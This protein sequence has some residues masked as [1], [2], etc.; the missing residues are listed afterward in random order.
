MMFGQP[1]IELGICTRWIGKMKSYNSKH[2]FTRFKRRRKRWS[3]KKR[4]R[5]C[6]NVSFVKLCILIV[7]DK[8]VKTTKVKFNFEQFLFRRSRNEPCRTRDHY[9]G[10]S[11]SKLKQ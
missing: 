1:R 2:L 7:I 8:S 10:I 3:E 11:G 9:C 4:K 6:Y 5:L